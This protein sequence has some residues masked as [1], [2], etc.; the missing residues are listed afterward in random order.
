MTEVRLIIGSGGV[1]KTTLV[2]HLAMGQVLKGKKVLAITFDPSLRLG[3]L[4]NHNTVK[5]EK[6]LEIF[7]IDPNKV[8]AILLQNLK[9][10][11]Q[12]DLRSNKLFKNL[13]EEIVGL[14]EF[15][16]LYYLNQAMHS[17]KYD[18]IVVDTPPFQ[19]ALD[20]FEAPQK[21]KNM[22]ESKVLRFF[23]GPQNEGL[24]S[25]FV[26]SSGKLAIKTLRNLT[27]MDFFKQLLDFIQA[28][29]DMQPLI[30]ETLN[31]CES[32]FRSGK[33]QIDYI[34]LYSGSQVEQAES[35]ILKLADLNL[36]LSKY[37]LSKYP[38]Q[39]EH[40]DLITKNE[41]K[42]FSDYIDLKKSDQKATESRLRTIAE[43]YN[44]ETIRIP[45]LTWNPSDPYEVARQW[46][47][48]I[49]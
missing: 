6:N 41:F 26:K 3:D 13:L 2:T 48:I 44:L 37:Y 12:D 25:S 15:T 45:Y 4:L 21:L 9:N 34:S 39:L 16:S 23:L 32:D 49:R 19:N 27:G 33:I 31:S 14:Q 5:D 29:E 46:D 20:F 38:G 11:N 30:L 28:L 22:F 36:K 42:V 47:D 18:Y 17:N 35:F 7:L 8:F 43:K 40:T 1:G 10:Q 24:M